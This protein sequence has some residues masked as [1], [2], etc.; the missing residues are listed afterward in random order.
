MP[1]VMREYVSLPDKAKAVTTF[2][3]YRQPPSDDDGTTTTFDPRRQQQQFE[4]FC[5]QE[6]GFRRV[7]E[8]GNFAVHFGWEGGGRFT[9]KELIDYGLN[10]ETINKF[11]GKS[12]S[13]LLLNAGEAYHRGGFCKSEMRILGRF[14]YSGFG[15]KRDNLIN[16]SVSQSYLA[17]IASKLSRKFY[18]L[19]EKV[20]RNLLKRL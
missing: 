10:P 16:Y 4:K 1:P 9:T 19:H 2:V 7:S 11:I 6:L 18:D 17:K 20:Y 3:P 12:G 14:I 8:I 5:V 15:D 13:Y